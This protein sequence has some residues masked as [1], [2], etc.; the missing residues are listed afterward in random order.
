MVEITVRGRA[1]E[2][3]SAELASVTVQSRWTAPSADEAMRAVTDAHGRLVE[4]AKRHEAAGALESWHADRVWI[5]HQQEWVGE[6]EPRRLTYTAA[7]A[8]TLRFTDFEVLGTWLGEVGVQETHEVGGIGWSLTEETERELARTARTRAIADAAERAA[9]YAAAAGLA[10]PVV[11]GIQ[12]PGTTPPAPRAAKARMETMAFAAAG[13]A[14]PAVE[15]EA[16]EIEVRAAVE[17][18]FVADPQQHLG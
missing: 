9:D 5:S 6:G 14:A 15:L 13:D 4:D 1:I 2:R 12:E 17:V 3:A 8:V 10:T 18:R 16:G 11:D 7:A